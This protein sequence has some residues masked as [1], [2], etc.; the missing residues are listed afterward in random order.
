MRN[1]ITSLFAAQA[2]LISAYSATVGWGAAIDRGVGLFSGGVNATSPLAVGSLVRLGFFSGLSVANIQSLAAAGDKSALDSAFREF[3]TA[4]IGQG[5]GNEPGTW[6]RSSNNS[7][8]QFGGLTAYVWV[9]NAASLAAATQWGIF[10]GTTGWTFPADVDTGNT[11]LDVNSVQLPSGVIVGQSTLGSA[12][13]FGES[14]PVLRLVPVPEPSAGILSAIGL[15]ALGA[16]RR[17]SRM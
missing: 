2:L 9:Y 13:L 15:I 1:L 3:G 11:S 14:V 6:S 12:T 5:T 16:K 10:T 7:E 4:T 17:R 8:A